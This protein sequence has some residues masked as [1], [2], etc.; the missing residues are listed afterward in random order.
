MIEPENRSD[1]PVLWTWDRM[2]EKTGLEWNEPVYYVYVAYK[3]EGSV[4]VYWLTYYKNKWIWQGKRSR[5][6]SFTMLEKALHVA[7]A[8]SSG[9]PEISPSRFTIIRSNGHGKKQRSKNIE[10]RAK[11]RGQDDLTVA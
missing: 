10:D 9:I 5:R 2:I 11:D 1:Q 4:K 3:I 8:H 6:A 7:Y